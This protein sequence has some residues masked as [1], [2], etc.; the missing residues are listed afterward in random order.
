MIASKGIVWEYVCP[1]EKFPNR[2]RKTLF[3]PREF[4]LA[5]CDDNVCGPFQTKVMVNVVFHS[6]VC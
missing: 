2:V 4:D 1:S 5:V 6:T 3:T